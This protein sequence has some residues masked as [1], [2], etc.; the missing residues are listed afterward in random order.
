MTHKNRKNEDSRRTALPTRTRYSNSRGRARH[1]SVRQSSG[2]RGVA[3]RW[4]L[5]PCRPVWANRSIRCDHT[6]GPDR[7]S[8][9]RPIDQRERSW[10]PQRGHQRGRFGS[11]QRQCKSRQASSLPRLHPTDSPVLEAKRKSK[12]VLCCRILGKSDNPRQRDRLAQTEG[13]QTNKQQTQHSTDIPILLVVD[14]IAILDS[15]C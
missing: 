4:L 7:S 1:S 12:P 6:R 8:T 11:Q 10:L 13:Q 14:R 15:S 2:R 9:D 3:H 5:R